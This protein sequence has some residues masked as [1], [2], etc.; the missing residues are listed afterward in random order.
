MPS[1]EQKGM[2]VIIGNLRSSVPERILNHEPLPF[3]MKCRDSMSRLVIKFMLRPKTENEEEY[4]AWNLSIRNAKSFWRAR[5]DGACRCRFNSIAPQ[6]VCAAILPTARPFFFPLL[7]RRRR[8]QRRRR[9]GNSSLWIS[10]TI[11]GRFTHPAR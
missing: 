8:R 9:R 7:W 11:I 6:R 2:E 1:D 10:M 3:T 5:P 4:S